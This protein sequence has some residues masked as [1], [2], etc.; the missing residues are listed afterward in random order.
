MLLQDIRRGEGV[1]L[2]DPLG[3]IAD[4]IVDH[5]PTDRINETCYWNV[6][7]LEWPIGFNILQGFPG[8]ERHATVSRL[9]AT[10][11]GLWDLSPARTPS[12]WNILSNGVAALV[13]HEHASLVWLQRFLTDDPW[14]M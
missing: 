8:E 1:C 4:E 3:V 13:E 12:I 9:L 5:I 6:A 14:R 11:A 2:I 10:F 7:D